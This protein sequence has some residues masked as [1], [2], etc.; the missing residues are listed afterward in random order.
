MGIKVRDKRKNYEKVQHWIHDGSPPH[1]EVLLISGLIL[2][3]W[4]T[5]RGVYTERIHLSWTIYSRKETFDLNTPRMWS[6]H[7]EVLEIG[8]RKMRENEWFPH[9]N[10]NRNISDMERTMRNFRLKIQP[11]KSFLRFFPKKI[12]TILD[13][14]SIMITQIP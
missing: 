14:F 5:L 11:M 13:F 7:V 9:W 12:F 4:T 6:M 10:A 3:K 8:K 1:D 2:R